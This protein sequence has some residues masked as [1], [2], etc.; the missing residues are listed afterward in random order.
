MHISF[1]L[2]L[3]TIVVS[4]IGYSIYNCPLPEYSGDSGPNGLNIL[5]IVTLAAYWPKTAMVDLFD[6]RVSIIL[7]RE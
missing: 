5:D 1:I 3:I 4:F 2:F 6:L 7:G